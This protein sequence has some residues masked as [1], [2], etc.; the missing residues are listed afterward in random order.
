[1]HSIRIAAIGTN[2]TS[3]PALLC[4]AL[5]CLCL[6]TCGPSLHGAILDLYDKPPCISAGL[7]EAKVVAEIGKAVRKI[8]EIVGK[9]SVEH[10]TAG[11]RVGN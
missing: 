9:L 2:R 11:I 7:E 10:R 1:M 3:F 5:G 6:L 4:D 8:L